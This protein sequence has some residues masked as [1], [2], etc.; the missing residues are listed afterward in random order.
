[1][2]RTFRALRC[3]AK[4][5][6]PLCV[7]PA[8]IAQSLAG[9]MPPQ[10][11][12]AMDRIP[13]CSLLHRPAGEMYT[14]NPVAPYMRDILRFGIKRA[15]V[16]IAFARSDNAVLSRPRIVERVYFSR[17]DGPDGQ[18]ADAGKL[19][20]IK[21]SGLQTEL[22]WIAF[23]RLLK[24]HELSFADRQPPG[25]APMAMFFA[26]FFAMPS[27]GAPIE[28]QEGILPRP[29]LSAMQIAARLGDAA[30]IRRMTASSTSQATLNR[31]LAYAAG[32]DYD[33]T[34]VFESLVRAGADVNAR[35]DDGDPVIVDAFHTPC[36]VLALIRLG[37]RVT[38][39]D[40]DGE[41]VLQ[42][43]ERLDFQQV[44]KIIRDAIANP[45]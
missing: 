32:S 40:R 2:L 34:E 31:V 15:V 44:V 30:A 7:T 39:H 35:D 9:Q 45:R 38:E 37:A 24:S 29:R 13:A 18:I 17:L 20:A 12:R 16:A 14:P 8:L 4:S 41:S 6:L 28:E 3:I 27:I 10:V 26:Q 1:M 42:V 21:N 25:S 33:N 36:N 43:A 22:D 11:Q 5:F 19:A 23:S